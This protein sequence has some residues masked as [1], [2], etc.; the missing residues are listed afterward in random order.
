MCDVYTLRQIKNRLKTGKISFKWYGN[1]HKF[2]IGN[3]CRTY[4]WQI[5]KCVVYYNHR[6]NPWNKKCI[7]TGGKSYDSISDCKGNS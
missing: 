2:S 3:L 6:E 4:T 7:L 5:N 1:L